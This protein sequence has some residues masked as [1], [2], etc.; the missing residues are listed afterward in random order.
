MCCSIAH[1]VMTDFLFMWTWIRHKHV[2]LFHFNEKSWTIWLSKGNCFYKNRDESRI[3]LNWMVF[4]KFMGC[5]KNLQVDKWWNN[6]DGDNFTRHDCAWVRRPTFEMGSLTVC[7]FFLLSSQSLPIRRIHQWGTSL[8]MHAFEKL[9]KIFLLGKRERMYRPLITSDVSQTAETK[10]ER[11]NEEEKH[12]DR[13]YT[14]IN[15]RWFR[16]KWIYFCFYFIYLLRCHIFWSR[17]TCFETFW[18]S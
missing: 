11:K 18:I 2:F 12:M 4:V 6:L 13:P 3:Y 17:Y 8:N 15:R 9:T 14:A 1:L 16:Y 10:T 7:F 5:S